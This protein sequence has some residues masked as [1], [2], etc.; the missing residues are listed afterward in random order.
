MARST[1]PKPGSKAAAVKKT[2]PSARRQREE[3][4]GSDRTKRQRKAV[5]RWSDNPLSALNLGGSRGK[6]EAAQ[7]GKGQR[8]N[9]S[10]YLFW[11]RPLR[12]LTIFC[13]F[14]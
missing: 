12:I 10:I 11:C 14:E 3:V 4:G 6:L 8:V 1:A 5:A 9:F 7:S 2:K 13:F